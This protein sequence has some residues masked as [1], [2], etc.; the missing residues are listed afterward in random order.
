MNGDNVTYF[1]SFGFEHISKE[2]EK[3][4]YGKHKLKINIFRIQ[5][6][7]SIMCGCFC[8]EFL[9]FMLKFKNSLDYSNLISSN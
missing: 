6:K 8:I 7:D 1:D 5:A 4:K 3:K 9:D 2:I